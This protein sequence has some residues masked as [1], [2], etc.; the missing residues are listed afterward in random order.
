MT[1]NESLQALLAESFSIALAD[2]GL[3]RERMG[4]RLRLQVAA[5]SINQIGQDLLLLDRELRRAAVY[6]SGAG[7]LTLQGSAPL[8][9]EVE[10]V[11]IGSFWADVWAAGGLV[12]EI[13]LSQPLQLL[14][15]A[16]WLIQHFRPRGREGVIEV[17]DDLPLEHVG[18][19]ID[20]VSRLMNETLA[21]NPDRSVK[22]SLT[23]DGVV[24]EID[25]IRR[26]WWRSNGR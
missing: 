19:D 6:V 15:T 25:R 7:D 18:P 22:V 26:L 10:K 16:D 13:M 2:E 8:D 14:I 4:G 17:P 12:S 20:A 5:V 11:G 9:L 21:S 3:L 1:L 24:F 23:T